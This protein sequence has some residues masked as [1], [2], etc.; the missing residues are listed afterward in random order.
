MWHFLHFIQTHYIWNIA[1]VKKV[2]CFKL[3]FISSGKLH[4]LW[5]SFQENDLHHIQNS[6]DK[7]PHTE[8]VIYTMNGV[9]LLQ[10]RLGI[11]R[12]RQ[13]HISKHCAFK[14]LSSLKSLKCEEANQQYLHI[15][16]FPWPP[17][18]LWGLYIY[19]WEFKAKSWMRLAEG[20]LFSSSESS[21]KQV[22][23]AYLTI[24]CM[25]CTKTTGIMHAQYSVST[26]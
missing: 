18:F 2:S 7:L 24:L 10:S 6:T 4:P 12:A 17:C 8:C 11:N 23:S 1:V 21:L 13:K 19:I 5:Y 22:V 16:L 25:S 9:Q 20:P 3:M 15:S 26:F 14:I